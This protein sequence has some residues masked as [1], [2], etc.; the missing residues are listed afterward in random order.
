MLIGL[1]GLIGSGKG[2]VADI[3]VNDHGF[4]QMS[5]AGTLKDAV[6]QIFSWD[7]ALLEGDTVES[8]N[9]RE[10]VDP[11]WAE[12]LE[13]PHL[14]PR[15]VLQYLGTNVIR[16]HFNDNIWML[17]LERRLMNVSE[18]VVLSDVRFPNELAMLRRLGGT[19][20]RVKRGNDPDWFSV[21]T[22]ANSTEVAAQTAK[23]H[24]AN[25]GVHESEWAWVGTEFDYIVLNDGSLD[26]LRD[27]TGQLVSR[28]SSTVGPI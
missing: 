22:V 12:K 14:T 6:A 8:R 26:D 21:A 28:L 23:E 24:L 27:V 17:A 5:F 16:T 7:R 11:W 1:S 15:W 20:L 13:V 9:W 3:L 19:A 18:N 4:V 10:Q 25:L 2:T